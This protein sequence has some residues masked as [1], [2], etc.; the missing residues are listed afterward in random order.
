MAGRQ[1]RGGV[2]ASATRSAVV[3]AVRGVPSEGLAPQQLFAADD[4]VPAS[5]NANDA[6]ALAEVEYEEHL[7]EVE[8]EALVNP[9]AS[10]SSQPALDPPQPP[11]PQI[12]EGIEN[13]VLGR[14]NATTQASNSLSYQELALK[15][16][17]HEQELAKAQAKL[18]AAV[19]SLE[20][21]TRDCASLLA[22]ATKVRRTAGVQHKEVESFKATLK[23][24]EAYTAQVKS[25]AAATETAL[26]RRIAQLLSRLGE[27]PPVPGHLPRALRAPRLQDAPYA[28]GWPPRISTQQA[29]QRHG[30]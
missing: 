19:K 21:K 8:H 27:G 20:G 4:C 3:R 9:S 26:K 14:R 17:Y 6:A 10:E 15:A 5:P 30:R 25:T 29:Q 22:E 1:T 18:E 23:R 7:A 24:G 12:R 28:P 16:K 2:G 11:P 13:A